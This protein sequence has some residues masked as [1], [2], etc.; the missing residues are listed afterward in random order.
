[1]QK[2]QQ[3]EA[4]SEADWGT[5]VQRE[6]V[7]RPLAE[8]AQLSVGDIDDAMSR[9]SMSRSVLYKLIHRYKLPKTRLDRVRRSA[10]QEKDRI[11]PI[12]AKLRPKSANS[13]RFY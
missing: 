7:I 5:A 11:L 9:L 3:W 8:Q 6:A 10:F 13:R 1:M 4:A 12:S 2:W